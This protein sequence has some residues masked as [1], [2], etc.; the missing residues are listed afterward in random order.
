MTQLALGFGTEN[1]TTVHVPSQLLDSRAP[2]A[3]ILFR[4][5]RTREAARALGP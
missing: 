3:T 2:N 4:V 1:A 5:S